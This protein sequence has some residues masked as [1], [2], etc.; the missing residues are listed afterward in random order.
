MDNMD[1]TRENVYEG[2]VVYFRAKPDAD[3]TIGISPIPS[4]PRRSRAKEKMEN[5]TFPP[6]D[7]A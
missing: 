1:L 7:A 6:K 4:R 2:K 5:T 3:L